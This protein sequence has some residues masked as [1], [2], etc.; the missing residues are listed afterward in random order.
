MF[1]S[2]RIIVCQ[3]VV[4]AFTANPGGANLLGHV[5]CEEGHVL[6]MK[7]LILF[8]SSVQRLSLLHIYPLRA[9]DLVLISC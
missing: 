8:Q 4:V 6:P 1:D 5:S 2:W 3:Q 9:F 7:V